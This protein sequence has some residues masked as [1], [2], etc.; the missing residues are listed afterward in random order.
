MALVLDHGQKIYEKNGETFIVGT[1]RVTGKKYEVG[2][3]NRNHLID[4]LNG[5]VIQV[6]LKELSIGDREFLI[7]G[8]S[9]EGWD[10]MFG[11]PTNSE[12]YEG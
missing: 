1:C 2:P 11:E 12:E 10:K 9:P 3:I 8:T 6:A 4:W 7:S 5:E